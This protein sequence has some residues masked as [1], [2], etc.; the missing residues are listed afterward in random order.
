MTN[1]VLSGINISISRSNTTRADNS[2]RR[3]FK[4]WPHP[5]NIAINDEHQHL[6]AETFDNKENQEN[7]RWAP[8]IS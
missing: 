8:S 7:V 5:S 6:A 2:I 3:Y 4:M 1:N